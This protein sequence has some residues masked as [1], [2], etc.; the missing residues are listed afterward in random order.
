MF[1][2]IR[3]IHDVLKGAPVCMFC[4]TD[5]RSPENSGYTYHE[6]Y[7]CKPCLDRVSLKAMDY[8]A[9]RIGWRHPRTMR[10]LSESKRREIFNEAVRKYGIRQ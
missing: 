4:D 3:D 1:E 5:D 8:F 2:H 9:D 10:P 6:L 7:T